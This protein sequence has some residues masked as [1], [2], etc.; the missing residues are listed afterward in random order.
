MLFRS[1]TEDARALSISR[2]ATDPSPEAHA[3]A[4]LFY[5][6]EGDSER[7]VYHLQESAK[8][9]P[10]NFVVHALLIMQHLKMA[11]VDSARNVALK[12][13]AAQPHRLT[14][15]FTVI[16]VTLGMEFAPLYP[17]VIEWAQELVANDATDTQGNLFLAQSLARTNSWERVWPA[18]EIVLANESFSIKH[19]PALVEILSLDRKSSC[20][21]RVCS[22]V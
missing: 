15:L 20:R 2:L 14:A 16:S 3:A 21:E 6:A 13:I 8:M 4:A 7:N 12:Y 19:L 9:A 11:K 18:L 1:K 17:F 5:W 10:A 22:T